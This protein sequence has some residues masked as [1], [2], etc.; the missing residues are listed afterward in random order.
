LHYIGRPLVIASVCLMSALMAVA[1]YAS[2]VTNAAP[3]PVA[4]AEKVA[5]T[6]PEPAKR[7]S[8]TQN[9]TSDAVPPLPGPAV[10]QSV[11]RAAVERATLSDPVTTG[12][13]SVPAAD[14]TPR[15]ASGTA[16]GRASKQ[17]R[18]PEARV[19]AAQSV[20]KTHPRTG[21]PR[22]RPNRGERH[23]ASRSGSERVAAAAPAQVCLVL[24]GCF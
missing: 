4:Q 19:L 13:V 14:E 1:T 2:R 21:S 5:S 9:V 22:G 11:A 18:L 6:A 23:W 24:I 17:P 16:T 20:A 3:N 7:R 15:T 8:Y 10:A 12:S